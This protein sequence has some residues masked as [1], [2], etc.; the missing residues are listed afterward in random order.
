MLLKLFTL[1]L[2]QHVHFI[3]IDKTLSSS[4][5]ERYAIMV[6]I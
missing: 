4:E 5:T 6:I 1:T 2:V 3:E